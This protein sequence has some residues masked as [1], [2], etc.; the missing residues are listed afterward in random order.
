MDEDN[1][2]EL[3]LAPA[4]AFLLALP[5]EPDLRMAYETYK[6][7]PS[8]KR[9]ESEKT[10]TIFS[11]ALIDDER[12][13][14][15]ANL[16]VRALAKR[17]SRNITPRVKKSQ[18]NLRIYY[19][20]LDVNLPLIDCYFVNDTRFWR[21]VVLA[22]TKDP[23]LH[24]KKLGDYDW[25]GNGISLKYVE[26]VEACLAAYWPEKEMTKL[27]L[28]VTKYVKNMHI[29]R[30]QSQEEPYFNQFMD[31]EGALDASSDFSDESSVSSD[32]K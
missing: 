29:S 7:S 13:G 31:T 30:L 10:R 21:R 9:L 14:T 11:E 20:T 28:L 12:L 8:T 27:A 1:D 4:D 17:S 5:N 23:S 2:N 18:A 3:V 24:L 19:D 26:L 16:S 22:K 32:E 25:R 6:T 15:L